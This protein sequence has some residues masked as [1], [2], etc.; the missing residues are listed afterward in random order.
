MEVLPLTRIHNYFM[1]KIRRKV[2]ENLIDE[3]K[4][5]IIWLFIFVFVFASNQKGTVNIDLY[6]LATGP[7][8]FN[9]PILD[10][11][12]NCCIR[13]DPIR[14]KPSGK[15]AGRIGFVCEMNHVT[16]VAVVFKN[17]RIRNLKPPTGLLECNPYLKYAYSKHWYV[18]FYKYFLPNFQ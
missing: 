17:I 3:I 6:S 5:R 8:E 1:E 12:Q 13:S 16:N 14:F 9:L 11:S 4:I 2:P 15:P 10:V 7:A 18:K